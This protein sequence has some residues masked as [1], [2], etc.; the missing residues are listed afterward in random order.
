MSLP[1]KK[2]GHS[3]QRKILGLSR[4]HLPPGTISTADVPTG[5][6]SHQAITNRATQS[7]KSSVRHQK[8]AQHLRVKPWR[9]SAEKQGDCHMYK[10]VFSQTLQ[11]CQPTLESPG[12][13]L[14]M[15][16]PRPCFRIRISRDTRAEGSGSW[17]NV[18]RLSHVQ[19][20]TASK[21]QTRKNSSIPMP[22]VFI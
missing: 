7:Q 20:H 13:F 15:Q 6:H 11:N 17:G 10:Y 12:E 16:I 14:Q 8:S 21:R 19:N 18:K 2:Q 22:K 3:L 4:P 5:H 9:G 1:F